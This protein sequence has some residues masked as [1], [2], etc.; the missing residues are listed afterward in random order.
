LV[1]VHRLLHEELPLLPLWQ[2]LDHF[3]YRKTLVGIG[4]R[5]VHLYQDVE[6]WKVDGKLARSEP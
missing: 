5:P 2:T 3:A 4:S 1:T 6:R